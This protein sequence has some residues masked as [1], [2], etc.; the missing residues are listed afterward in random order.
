MKYMY[1]GWHN[2]SARVSVIVLVCADN[3]VLNHAQSILY[4]IIIM[5]KNQKKKKGILNL[6]LPAHM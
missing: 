2:I 3:N 5:V 6:P 4:N 1:G